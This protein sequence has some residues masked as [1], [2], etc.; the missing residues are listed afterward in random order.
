[1]HIFHAKLCDIVNIYYICSVN[2]DER[3]EGDDLSPLLS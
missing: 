1:M 2:E 3:D